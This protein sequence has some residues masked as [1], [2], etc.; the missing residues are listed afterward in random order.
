MQSAAQRKQEPEESDELGA[1][2]EEEMAYNV[3]K[4]D[5]MLNGLKACI[6][7]PV[8]FKPRILEPTGLKG[9]R[10]AQKT[11]L[12]D[13]DHFLNNHQMELISILLKVVV[14][15]LTKVGAVE[16]VEQIPHSISRLLYLCNQRSDILTEREIYDLFLFESNKIVI[17][18]LRSFN[19]T[20]DTHARLKE[21]M[22]TYG[23]LPLL[24][25]D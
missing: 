11:V 5:G 1:N 23:A 15:L 20:V 4:V 24:G 7:L 16:S 6:D 2:S 17:D 3:E 18:E 9:R 8:N 12:K 14:E 22:A 13:E 21:I 10:D 19:Q 25:T